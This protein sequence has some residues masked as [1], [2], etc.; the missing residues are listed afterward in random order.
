MSYF[1]IKDSKPLTSSVAAFSNP[2]VTLLNGDHLEKTPAS[3]ISSL[4]YYRMPYP[5]DN[6]T[7]L[8][9]YDNGTPIVYKPA[10]I[11]IY[12][13]LHNNITGLTTETDDPKKNIV[14]E[15]V[16]EYNSDANSNSLF[17][18]ILLKK[19]PSVSSNMSSID[20]II[21]MSNTDISDQQN[22]TR[23]VDL[24]FDIDIPGKQTFF[25]YIDTSL[26]VN[27]IVIVL[28]NPIIISSNDVSTIISKLSP[29]TSL[30]KVSAPNNYLNITAMA[31]NQENQNNEDNSTKISKDEIYI[32][33]NPTNDDLKDATTY[34]LPIGKALSKDIQKMD[35][36][37][38]AVNFFVFIIG[39]AFIYGVVPITY[40]TL[41]IDNII[42]AY[43][44][45]DD[46]KKRIRS[47]DVILIMGL[48]YVMSTFFYYGFKKGGD[49]Q[50]ATYGIFVIVFLLLSYII[51]QFYKASDTW[52]KY[53][54]DEEKEKM[55]YDFPDI[56][57]LLVSCFSYAYLFNNF[58]DGLNGGATMPVLVLLLIV[59]F[60]LGILYIASKIDNFSDY[61]SQCFWAI[62]IG[63]P[64][65]AYLMGIGK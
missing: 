44:N 24:N 31:D 14:G 20:K 65:F 42:D 62:L 9:Y 63:V 17:L 18:C 6:N 61:F 11:Y 26:F 45:D 54:K 21:N 47:A 48:L 23:S 52:I 32:D 39:I 38:T 56:G 64:I 43:D 37:K 12:G 16:I 13:L 29:D 50:M 30:F 3:F 1:D 41:V 27:N 49:P 36:M 4:Y 22:Y 35:F 25:K 58:K 57:R 55:F 15:M 40:K 5:S 10:Y 53:I 28:L 2:K 51:I 34:N 7:R 19:S 33:C 8:T 60:V 46:R 59:T